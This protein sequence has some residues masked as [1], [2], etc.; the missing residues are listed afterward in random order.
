MSSLPIQQY[1]KVDKTSNPKRPSNL[2]F[3][4]RV[5]FNPLYQLIFNMVSKRVESC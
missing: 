3:V 2:A 1:G 5:K 4:K